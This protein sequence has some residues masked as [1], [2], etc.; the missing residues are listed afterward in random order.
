M[1][2]ATDQISLLRA[3]LL[4]ADDGLQAWR[5]WY[6]QADLE[7]LSPGIYSLLPQLYYNIHRL[8]PDHPWMVRLKGIA[9]Y[10]WVNN[11]TRLRQRQHWGFIMKEADI[12]IRWVGDAEI[13]EGF[14][15]QN[16]A[17]PIFQ[18]VGIVPEERLT[19][20]CKMLQTNGE[21]RNR[22]SP[23][24]TI[25][26]LF[27]FANCLTLRS[28]LFPARRVPFP[29]EISPAMH[30]LLA[31]LRFSWEHPTPLVCLSDAA[32]ILQSS[33]DLW[34]ELLMLAQQFDLAL[35]LKSTLT[36]LQAI[37]PLDL[38]S[39]SEQLAASPNARREDAIRYR[40]PHQRHL[41]DR[42]WLAWLTYGK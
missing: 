32:R 12:P 28:W 30:F 16:G 41:I 35:P 15:P 38:R 40:P 5:V 20:A 22:R 13:V 8:D 6:P 39:V 37:I 34:N 7:T 10:T 31:C 36:C 42:I 17:R 29:E 23:G 9:R 19:F 25:N 33:P 26:G 21:R 27:N 18:I 1:T 24:Q 2:L 3:V 11:Q 4:P 14:Y